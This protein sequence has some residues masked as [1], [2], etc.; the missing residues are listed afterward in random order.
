MEPIYRP[1]AGLVK[2]TVM[3]M[4]WRV[5]V[6]GKE[7]V[8]ET[9]PAVVACNHV[10][11]LDPIMVGLA[12]EQRGRLPRFLAKREL[13]EIPVF[14]WVL[15]QM[16]QVPVDRKGAAS[17]A[18][19]DGIER[20]R[21]GYLLA[22]F[23]EATIR[24]EFDPANGKSGAARL[25]LTSGV[26]LI[27]MAVWGGQAVATKGERVRGGRKAPLAMHIGAPVVPEPDEG[28]HDLTW[29]LMLRIGELA[30]AAQAEV[31][32]YRT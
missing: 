24:P 8:P 13:F 18:Y 6:T 22:V 32:A 11:Y 17:V 28:P 9:G 5:L 2:A 7:H 29:R 3:V 14:G 10:S 15:R 27:P 26:P 4:G 19:R 31:E 25:A 1:V 12:T 23:P 20:L 16:K 30:K 21:Q